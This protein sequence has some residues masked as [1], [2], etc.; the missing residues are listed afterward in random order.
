MKKALMWVLQNFDNCFGSICSAIMI[1]LLF[2]QV[3]TRFV[4]RHSL[5]W[6][7]EVALPLFILSIY[8]GAASAVKNNQHLRI[9]ALI[10]N[11]GPRA[12]LVLDI[13]SDVVSIAFMSFVTY[14]MVLVTKK[15]HTTGAKLVITGVFK[16]VIYS[17]VVLGFILILLR[18]AENIFIR[19]REYRKAEKERQQ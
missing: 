1:V 13:V 14:A 11:V 12:R 16:W 4:F 6:T 8:Y 15:M 5:T 10:D 18:F 9:V 2:I 3:I 17:L 19:V 7:E